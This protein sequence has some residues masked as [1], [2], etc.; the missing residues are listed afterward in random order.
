MKRQKALKLAGLAIVLLVLAAEG[1]LVYHINSHAMQNVVTVGNVNIRLTE[2][3]YERQRD[4][5]ESESETGQA[6]VVEC[7][8]WR[9]NPQRS[10]YCGGRGITNSVLKDKNCG[11]RTYRVSKKRSLRTH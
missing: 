3:E 6:I 9:K 1:I 10:H 4:E 7:K 5:E 2:P 8:T 11:E